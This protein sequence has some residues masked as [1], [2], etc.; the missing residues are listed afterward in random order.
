MLPWGVVGA[1]GG[2]FSHHHDQKTESVFGEA[3]E[4]HLEA[5]GLIEKELPVTQFAGIQELEAEV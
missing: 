3:I 1:P 2:V 5:F 4:A